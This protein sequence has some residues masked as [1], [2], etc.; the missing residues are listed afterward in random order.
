M[1]LHISLLIILNCIAYKDLEMSLPNVE[2]GRKRRKQTARRVIRVVHHS[3]THQND[4]VLVQCLLVM[5]DDPKWKGD[6][7]IFRSK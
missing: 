5:A 4:A 3:W 1:K 7:G 2:G 6:N